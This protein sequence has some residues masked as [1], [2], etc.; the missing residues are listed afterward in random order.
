MGG[1]LPRGLLGSILLVT[2]MAAVSAF[3]QV[4]DRPTGRAHLVRDINRT[5]RLG[6]R[7][8]DPQ[9]MIR[10][11][12]LV[13]FVAFMPGT[14]FEIWRTDG[15]P[16]GT[17]LLNEIYPGPAGS[18]LERWWEAGGILYFSVS[19]EQSSS[20]LWR[21]DG[22]RAGT[23]LVK[24][25][26]AAAGP[27]LPMA[28]HQEQPLFY[29]TESFEI[30]TTDGTEAGTVPVKTGFSYVGQG[31]WVNGTL[32]FPANS[33]AG[34]GLWK[35]DGTAGGTVLVKSTCDD[36]E[37]PFVLDRAAMNGKLYFRGFHCILGFG[38]F[39]SDGTE[40]GTYMVKG[41]D[42]YSW[43]GDPSAPEGLTAVGDTLYFSVHDPDYGLELWKSDGLSAGTVL[44]K[45]VADGPAWS[46]PRGFTDAAGTAFFVAN[47]TGSD[48]RELWKTDGTEQG[49][50]LVKD[51]RPGPSSP[52]IFEAT[53]TASDGALYFTAD[54]GSH[55]HELWRSDGSESG[56]VLL[57]D[58]NPGAAGSPPNRAIVELNGTVLFAA[59]DPVLGYELWKTD[60]T[61]SGTVLVKDINPV[62]T[63][64]SSV[65]LPA[66]VALGHDLY[67]IASDGVHG[68][69]LWRSNGTSEG[70]ALVK[71]FVPPGIN[72]SRA[73]DIWMELG[74]SLVLNAFDP[75][76]GGELWKS[77]GTEAG[78]VLVRDVNPG[79]AEASLQ[80]VG[81]LD[82]AVY[83]AASDGG[84]R[85][86]LWR[87]DLTEAG[88]VRV[89]EDLGSCSDS[90]VLNGTLFFAGDDS[91]HGCE[92]WKLDGTA[93]GPQRVKDIRAAGTGYPP[94]SFMAMNGKL[95]FVV[96]DGVH[97]L[98]LWTSDGTE[99]G[100]A[101]VKDVFP[102]PDPSIRSDLIAIDGKIYFNA[103][104][105]THGVELWVSD[106]TEAGT[107]LFLELSPGL[108]SLHPTQL[109]AAGG[110]L[111]FFSLD[112][113]LQ[114]EVLWSSDG[115]E[116]GTVIVK[117][118]LHD[119]ESVTTIDDRLFFVSGLPG[120][121]FGFG[122]WRSDGTAKGT[123]LVQIIDRWSTAIDPSGVVG[124]SDLTK[125]GPR[126]FFF[127]N[128]G[129]A[130]KEPWAGWASVLAHRSGRAIADLR[131]EAN[132]LSL[133]RSVSSFLR[134]SLD[135]AE[136]G[137]E[138]D[139]VH[140]I[141]ALE[142]FRLQVEMQT[143]RWI[144]PD[145]SAA[146]VDFAR[147]IVELLEGAAR[148]E[149]SHLK[150]SR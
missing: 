14:G 139:D 107:H 43:V 49:T 140:A 65:F 39:A 70:T 17:F 112:P 130:G 92:L 66:P 103:D 30:W 137:L 85:R 83:F 75:D 46:F 55:G 10:A 7:G 135:A 77:D 50:V 51:I 126:L 8:S 148:H 61:E 26:P 123:A 1:S 29:T 147:Q 145:K 28:T 119:I 62:A 114:G 18:P 150:R 69:D 142:A 21:S 122:L 80:L 15:T 117:Q 40:F 44:V 54:D 101:L 38:L 98:E 127:A 121:D 125:V 71:D 73:P 4:L 79:P 89:M 2:Q 108:F 128:D 136:R 47:G 36:A 67:F 87:S 102:G 82:G 60:G 110:K 53:M 97:G 94:S 3:G 16:D 76:H 78:T 19:A 6:D 118:G 111:M 22:T 116:A 56:T 74:G 68:F 84:P 34:S 63:T 100:T 72:F 143:P 124:L 129:V 95:F 52:Q 144:P 27:I 23:Y 106:G 96:D 13:Y 120:R 48:G 146:L 31:V 9:A 141:A 12:N 134:A 90:A 24:R 20:H 45:D 81:T 93:A 57:K 33:A 5:P 59:V 32:L 86:S 109:S 35:S 58:V 64:S 11:G 138:Q 88:T 41:F 91:V 149:A 25:F 131:A 104:D 105:G 115:T 132:R 113:E 37:I 99:A 133:P 42:P